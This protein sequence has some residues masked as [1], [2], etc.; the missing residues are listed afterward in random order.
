M[1]PGGKTPETTVSLD[2]VGLGTSAVALTAVFTCELEFTAGMPSVAAGPA[3]SVAPVDGEAELDTW[4]ESSGSAL[5]PLGPLC[6]A[7]LEELTTGVLG[8]RLGASVG[9]ALEA[10]E[11][12]LALALSAATPEV[13]WL[14]RLTA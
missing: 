10:L 14:L 2:A 1:T 11:P 13:L 6:W 4:V 8:G 7:E 9:A 5:A 3:E 12:T